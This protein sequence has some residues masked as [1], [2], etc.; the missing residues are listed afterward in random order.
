MSEDLSIPANVLLSRLIPLVS[1]DAQLLAVLRGLAQEFLTLT[2][3][4]APVAVPAVADVAAGEPP[5]PEA[6]APAAP[7]RHVALPS[8][9]GIEVPVGW[10]RRVVAA[11]G[12]LQRIEARCR[13]KAE[14][15]RW[16]AARQRGLRDGADYYT[17]I[18][19]RDREII[20]KA[21]ALDDCF[22]WMSHSSAPI[23]ADLRL[24]EDVAGC[25]EAAAMAVALLRQVHENGEK[26]R[27]FLEKA[28]DLT[29]E[30]QSALRMAVELVDGKPD[31]DQHRIFHWL[32]QTSAEE[33]IAISRFMRLDDPAD[34]ARWNDL[35]E[36]ISQLDSEIEETPPA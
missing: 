13:L 7:S 22:L 6:V 3:V 16:A 26:Y 24:W 17:E 21:K 10:Y 12:D 15:A 30:A 8:A 23:P 28:I 27:G 20:S 31:S 19:P 29:A 1:Q 32:R 35:Q 36:R 9:P 11:E 34:P 25:F 18:E 4:A 5:L 33:Q 2:E 14:G